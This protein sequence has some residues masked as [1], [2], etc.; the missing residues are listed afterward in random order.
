[1]FDEPSL[2][3][4]PKFKELCSKVDGNKKL[5][6]NCPGVNLNHLPEVFQQNGLIQ[7]LIK[8][9]GPIFEVLEGYATDPE[10][11]FQGSSGGAISAIALYCLEQQSMSG[12]LHVTADS[13]RPYLNDTI[14][15]KNRESIL[16]AAGSRYSPASPCEKLDEIENAPTP[17]VF[18]G[19]PL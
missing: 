6:A 7:P 10:I 14:L 9:W 2:G 18:I 17:C 12:I 4:R 16:A 11:R 19:K 1:M 8:G 15:S 5:L 3:R 13:Q